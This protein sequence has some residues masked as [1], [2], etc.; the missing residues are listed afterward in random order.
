VKE[1]LPQS[2]VGINAQKSFTQGDEAGNVQ[3][4]IWRE[5]MKL[6]AVHKEKPTKKFVGRKRKSTEE[7]G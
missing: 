3:K 7:K 5:L 2:P 1:I 4:R 6:H